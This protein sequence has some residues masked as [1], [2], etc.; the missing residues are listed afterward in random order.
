VPHAVTNTVP[1]NRRL[2]L[3]R[4]KACS[5]VEWQAKHKMVKSKKKKKKK[6]KRKR[7][8]RKKERNKLSP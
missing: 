1:H 3:R 2:G 7:K 8:E 5:V 6:K 4:E